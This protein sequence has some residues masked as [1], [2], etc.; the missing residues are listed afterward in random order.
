NFSKNRFVHLKFHPWEM[1]AM[2]CLLS[3][4]NRKLG[5]VIVAVW[6]AGGKMEN[7]SETF[8][9]NRWKSAMESN[10]LGF[11]DYLG[12]SPVICN[13]WKHIRASFPFDKLSNIRD[14]FYQKLNH[15]TS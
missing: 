12:N 10:G 1:S 6:E 11:E 3:R 7:W 4:G 2:E 13:R 14:R 8:N 5:D 15:H 9:F